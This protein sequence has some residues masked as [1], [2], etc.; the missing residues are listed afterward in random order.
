MSNGPVSGEI[1]IRVRYAEVDRMGLLHHANYLV[2]LEQARV[3]L[4][5]AAGFPIAI[6]KIKGIFWF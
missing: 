3:D 2:Y 4:L 6:W 5:R 1:Q